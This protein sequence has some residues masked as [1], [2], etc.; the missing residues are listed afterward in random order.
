LTPSN[1]DHG[2]PAAIAVARSMRRVVDDVAHSLIRSAKA[3]G[4]RRRPR[5][6]L[7]PPRHA[8]AMPGDV[9]SAV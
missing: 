5:L 6:R 9:L 3:G 8:G 4:P 7:R 2:R 1:K